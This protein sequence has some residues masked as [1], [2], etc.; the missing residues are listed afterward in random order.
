MKNKLKYSVHYAFDR[1][2]SILSAFSSFVSFSDSL[3]TGQALNGRNVGNL[4]HFSDS[5]V[6]MENHPDSYLNT[7]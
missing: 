2:K 7:H 3:F 6:P 5:I 1:L 4:R